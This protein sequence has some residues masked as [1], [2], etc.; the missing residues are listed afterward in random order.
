MGRT[1]MS[2][3]SWIDKENVVHIQNRILLNW[4]EKNITKILEKLMKLENTVLSGKTQSQKDKHIMFSIPSLSTYNW[5]AVLMK[6]QQL[7]L[8]MAD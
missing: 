3:T 7:S 2:L 1:P 8:L 6:S 5:E 4:K